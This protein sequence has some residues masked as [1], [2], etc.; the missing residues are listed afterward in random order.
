MNF[1]ANLVG[2]TSWKNYIK[3]WVYFW[4][5][6][7]EQIFHQSF[8]FSFREKDNKLLFCTEIL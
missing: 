7:F 1:E 4:T 6:Y 2:Q 3:K 8:S 5:M